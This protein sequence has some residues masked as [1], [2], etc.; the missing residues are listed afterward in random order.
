MNEPLPTHEALQTLALFR[1][2]DLPSIAHYL[3]RCQVHLLRKGDVLPDPAAVNR[4]A[5]LVLDGAFQVHRGVE[6]GGAATPQHDVTF[7]TEMLM[8][9]GLMPTMCI[10]A[11]GPARVLE[12]SHDTLWSLAR[13]SHGVALNLLGLLL[14]R[15]ARDPDEP[16]AALRHYEHRPTIDHL[17]DLYNRR[18]IEEQFPREIL[19]ARL[20]AR[21][22]S[23]LM[24]GVDGLRAYNDAHGHAAG[25]ALLATLARELRTHLRPTDLV[26]RWGGDEFAVLLPDTQPEQAAR[27]AERVRAHLERALRTDDAG[28]TVS[29]GIAGLEAQDTLAEIVSRA[30]AALALAKAAGRNCVRGAEQPRDQSSAPT[31]GREDASSQS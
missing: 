23:L 10:V 3:E 30:T 4:S 1:N 2:V 19:R 12:L 28:P 22:L 17:T 27:A 6:E 13:A 9:E 16:G 18:G 24:L 5:Y 26:G 8:L 21:S 25:D 15:A 29:A 20:Q 31:A 14:R 11:K 7:T